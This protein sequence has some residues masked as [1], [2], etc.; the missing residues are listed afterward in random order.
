MTKKKCNKNQTLKRYFAR[1]WVALQGKDPC[2]VELRKLREEHERNV[3]DLAEMRALYCACLEK[4]EED[5]KKLKAA[6]GQ[7]AGLQK[8]VEN[9]RE[10]LDEREHTIKSMN[11]RYQSRLIQ[12]EEQLRQAEP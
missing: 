8:L 11:T 10:R 1:L 2:P 6:E 3:D 4:M 5:G 7:V 9:L 12:L